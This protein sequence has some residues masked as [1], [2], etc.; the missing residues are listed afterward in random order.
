MGT[1][2]TVGQ[3]PGLVMKLK[4]PKITVDNDEESENTGNWRISQESKA[5]YVD[6]GRSV[7]TVFQGFKFLLT[8]NSQ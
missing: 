3:S 2:L 7:H 1:A 5:K 8:I 6:G 4:I